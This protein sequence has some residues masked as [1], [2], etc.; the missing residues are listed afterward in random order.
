M[1]YQNTCGMVVVVK[2]IANSEVGGFFGKPRKITTVTHSIIHRE[3]SL[4][5]MSLQIYYGSHGNGSSRRKG[6]NI[7]KLKL[8]F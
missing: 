1:N 5:S 7:E 8:Y 6:L 3:P 2:G 4:C